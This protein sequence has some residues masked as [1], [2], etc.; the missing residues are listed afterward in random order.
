MAETCWPPIVD[1]GNCYFVVE[2]QVLDLSAV[3]LVAAVSEV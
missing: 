2:V 3:L 1:H